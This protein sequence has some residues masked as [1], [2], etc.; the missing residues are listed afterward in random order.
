MRV[1][2]TDIGLSFNVKQDMCCVFC[3]HCTDIF[4]DSNG[5]YMIDC[6]KSSKYADDHNSS[7]KCELFKESEEEA[8][9]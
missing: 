8:I 7:G 1:F 2:K 3:D 5:P 4:Y 9:T 6:D